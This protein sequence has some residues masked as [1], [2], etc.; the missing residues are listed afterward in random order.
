[1][2]IHAV[3]Y[4]YQLIVTNIETMTATEIFHDYNQRCYIENKIDELKEGFAFDQNSQRNL[5][6]NQMFLLIKMLAY[7]LHNWFKQAILPESW[8]SFEIQSVRR[9]FYH[10]AANI[11]GHGRYQYLRYANDREIEWLIRAV[12]DKLQRF[13]LAPA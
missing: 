4:A 8:R 2:D 1:M 7:N 10:L 3:K 9:K 6:A 11:C 13:R 5:K 12:I